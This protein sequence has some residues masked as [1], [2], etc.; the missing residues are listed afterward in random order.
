[1]VESLRAE[2]MDTEETLRLNGCLAIK[3][4][5]NKPSQQASGQ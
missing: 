4:Q 3:L 5:A 1:M 2:E